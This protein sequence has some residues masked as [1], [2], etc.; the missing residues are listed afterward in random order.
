MEPRA[1]WWQLET[2]EAHKMLKLC[3]IDANSTVEEIEAK[4]AEAEDMIKFLEGITGDHLIANR[5]LKEEFEKLR[6][7]GFPRGSTEAEFDAA[8]LEYLRARGRKLKE[9]RAANS[10][11]QPSICLIA[12]DVA[13][14]PAAVRQCNFV[15]AFVKLRHMQISTA[16]LSQNGNY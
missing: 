9:R 2:P 16:L 6:E 12:D 3:E 1:Y 7:K 11:E 13:D 10:Q 15:Q 14:D 5:Q 4:K 8:K